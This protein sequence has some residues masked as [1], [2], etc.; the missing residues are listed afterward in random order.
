MEPAV[1]VPIFACFEIIWTLFSFGFLGLAPD[2]TCELV[3][4]LEGPVLKLRELLFK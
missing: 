4:Y 3:Q 2:L 1:A